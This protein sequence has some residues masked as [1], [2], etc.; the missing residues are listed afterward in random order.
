MQKLSGLKKFWEEFR[1]NSRIY[2]DNLAAAKQQMFRFLGELETKADVMDTFK[3]I[4]G[5][6]PGALAGVLQLQ[7]GGGQGF[8]VG[9]L[10]GGAQGFGVGQQGFGPQQGFVGGGVQPG[11]GAGQP[12][13]GQGGRSMHYA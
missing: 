3:A 10:Y 8:G 13:Y 2:C 11:Y 4:A 1:E 6:H 12:G 5:P 9:G 7:N